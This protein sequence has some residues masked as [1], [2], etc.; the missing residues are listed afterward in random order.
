MELRGGSSYKDPKI[1]FG[2]VTTKLIMIL[3]YRDKVGGGATGNRFRI[4]SGNSSWNYES[5]TILGDAN[6]YWAC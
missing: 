2:E 5:L 1:I 4:G 3:N 6:W